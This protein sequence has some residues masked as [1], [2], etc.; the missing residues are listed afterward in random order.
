MS[1]ELTTEFDYSSLDKDVKGKLQCCVREF[2]AALREHKKTWLDLGKPLATAHAVL[3]D[4]KGEGSFKELVEAEFK[5]SRQTAYR[6]MWAWERFGERGVTGLLHVTTEAIYELAGP[7]VPDKAVSDALKLNDK[8]TYVNKAVADELIEKHT[9]KPEVEKPKPACATSA[10]SIPSSSTPDLPPVGTV[11]QTESGSQ[12]KGA[13]AG[14][15]QYADTFDP[16]ELSKDDGIADVKA[17]QVPYDEMLNSITGIKK[18]WNAIVGDELNGVYAVHKRQ[19][20]LTLLDDLR[21]AIA[22]AR[23]HALCKHCKGRGCEKC[24]GAGWWPRSVV[25][26]LTK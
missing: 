7:N 22:Q 13:Q 15:K 20:V 25:E 16:A 26:G 14:P 6:Y 9:V 18:I 21:G 8:G 3:V 17:L 23:P 2:N 19:R 5:I 10:D 11:H 12:G 24:S 1:K 4:A